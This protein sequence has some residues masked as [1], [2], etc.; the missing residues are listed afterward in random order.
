MGHRARDFCG[1]VSPGDA[2]G[3]AGEEHVYKV[4]GGDQ[5][6]VVQAIDLG[7]HVVNGNDGDLD[8]EQVGDLAREGALEA[9]GGGDGNAYEADLP[10]VGE[11]S[12][13]R[14]S[15]YLQVAGD[16]FHRLPLEVVHRGGL[17]SLFVTYCHVF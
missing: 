11:K 3:D 1:C 6:N 14:G 4:F 16:C 8:S 2:E 7:V 13:N 10:R 9:G 5:C 15:R 12:R 17:V